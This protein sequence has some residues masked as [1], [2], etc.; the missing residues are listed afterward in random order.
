MAVHERLLAEFGGLSGIRDH[1]LLESALHR[2]ENLFLYEK[3]DVFDL[4][5]A[6]A[7]GIVKNH[8]FVDGNKRTGFIVAAVFLE[9]NGKRLLATEIEST[10]TTLGL[11]AGSISEK[12]FGRWLKQKSSTARKK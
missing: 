12:E 11:A 4:A 3:P 2:P 8:P 10:I 7:F 9:T 1:G 6:Y 5:A